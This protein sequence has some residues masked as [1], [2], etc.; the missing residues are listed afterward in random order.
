MIKDAL[1]AGTG[2]LIS[3]AEIKILICYI[4]KSV[5]AP[6]PGKQ[7]ANLF[8]IEAIAN[9]FE[10]IEALESLSKAGNLRYDESDDSYTVTAE[11]AAAAETL[12]G[13]LPFTIRE[14]AIKVTAKLIATIRN[15]ENTTIN[16]IKENDQMFIECSAEDN[17]KTLL[18][19]KMLVGD[20]IEAQC[21]KQRFLEKSNE[22]YTGIINL[23]T[24]E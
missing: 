18:C 16:I 20:E 2:S 21:I 4:L 1:S 13:S 10:V 23:M 14:R 5:N 6:V 17:G 15:S 12:K 7:L 8:N 9:Y 22:I 11:G 19:V 24:T 3:S